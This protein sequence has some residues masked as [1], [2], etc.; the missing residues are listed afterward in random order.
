[1][2]AKE[3]AAVGMKAQEQGVARLERTYDELLES[4]TRVIKRSRD[5]TTM[6]EENKFILP[7]PED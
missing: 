3:A 7:P 2:F 1:M 6:M 5:L 4:A